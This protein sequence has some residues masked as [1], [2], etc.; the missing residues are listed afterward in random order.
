MLNDLQK[1]NKKLKEENKTLRYILGK[2]NIL[3]KATIMMAHYIIENAPD[4]KCKSI[5]QKTLENAESLCKD[6]EKIVKENDFD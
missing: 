1:E 4:E 5:A 2:N 3:D 6:L